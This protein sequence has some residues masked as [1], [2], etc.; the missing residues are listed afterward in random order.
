MEGRAGPVWT[1]N[2]GKRIVHGQSLIQGACDIL[3][4]WATDGERDYYLR[5][6]RDKKGSLEPDSSPGLACCAELCGWAIARAHARSGNAA[7]IAG[8]LGKNDKF[9]RAIGAFANIYADQ[10]EADYQAFQAAARRGA[11]PVELE[12]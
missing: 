12:S 3:L 10:V 8:Y 4:G 2:Q 9:E 1:E 5:Q 7:Q 11:I 6:I